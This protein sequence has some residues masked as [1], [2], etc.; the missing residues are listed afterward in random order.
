L[1]LILTGMPAQQ[2]V[3]SGV[4]EEE[5][6]QPLRPAWRRLVQRVLEASQAEAEFRAELAALV[7]PIVT[8]MTGP[9]G[10]GD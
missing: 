10:N 6:P 9:D 2:L 3:A 1:A 4:P 5:I 7:A 8:E